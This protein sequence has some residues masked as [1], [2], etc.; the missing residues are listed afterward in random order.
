MHFVIIMTLLLGSATAST[1]DKIKKLNPHA[2][3]ETITIISEV[4]KV[5]MPKLGLTDENLIL[6][7]IHKESGFA[8]TWKAGLDGEWGFL[9]VIPS[10]A[11]IQRALLK[12]RCTKEEQKFKTGDWKMC[13]CIEGDCSYPNVGYMVNN[14]YK[15]D[16][17]KA[18]K[19]FQY[20]PRAGLIVGLQELKYWKNKYDDKLKT[21]FW[22]T[23][24]SWLFKADEKTLYSNWWTQTKKNLGDN[25]WIVHHN[26]GGIIKQT[27]TARWYPRG[28]YNIYKKLCAM[29]DAC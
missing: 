19:F 29:D 5:W 7:I 12:Y 13:R 11:H 25:V 22:T 27:H 4:L 9:Q 2:T 16:A 17:T 24:P 28:V 8:R 1:E 26:Y 3:T 20:S 18:A 23:F 10:D 15:V 6:A 14:K 21:Q